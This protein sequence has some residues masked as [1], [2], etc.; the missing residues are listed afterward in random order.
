M[1]EARRRRGRGCAGPPGCRKGLREVRGG[2]SERG[3]GHNND[4]ETLEDNCPRR[5]GSAASQLHSGE[6]SCPVENIERINWGQERLVTLTRDY[7]TLERRHG[8]NKGLGRRRRLSGC[9]GKALVSMGRGNQ[10]ERESKLRRVPS[11]RHRGETHQGKG[12]DEASMV[13]AERARGH[14]ERWRSSEIG[15]ETVHER[16][17]ARGC[18]RVGE[19]PEQRRGGFE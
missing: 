4:A 18:L 7:G 12:H 11:C 8:H 16:R 6:Q 2:C 17:Q 10:R 5:D 1:A 3:N 14:G 9:A 19:M 13:V 15:E